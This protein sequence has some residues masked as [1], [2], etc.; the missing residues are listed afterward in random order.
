MKEGEILKKIYKFDHYWVSNYGNIY[1]DYSGKLRRLKPWLDSKGNYYQIGL[2]KNGKRYRFLVHRLVAKAFC[3]NSHNYKEVNHIDND[4]KNNKAENLE[5]CTRKHNLEQS[6]Q[7]M[8]PIRNYIECSLLK[9]GKIIRE[10]KSCREAARFAKE[11]YNA[12]PSV[13]EKYK[14]YKD[15]EIINKCND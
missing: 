4:S 5:W 15:L 14:K 11:Q 7:T 13:L 8:S 10:F 6:Y 12:S 1:S 2:C 3:N 9:N